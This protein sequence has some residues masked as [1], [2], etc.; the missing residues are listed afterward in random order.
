MIK[1]VPWFLKEDKNYGMTS[2]WTFL[3]VYS[4]LKT[5]ENNSE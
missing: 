3:C 2:G 4:Y 5:K 1:T